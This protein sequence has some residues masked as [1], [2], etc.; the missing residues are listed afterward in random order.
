MRTD[1]LQK[2]LTK[3]CG[4]AFLGVF[5]R[6]HLPVPTARTCVFVANTDPCHLDGQH[7]ICIHVDDEKRGEYFDSFGRAPKEICC[8]TSTN[9][10]DFGHLI[11][12]NYKAP[13]VRFV[14]NI[15]RFTVSIAAKDST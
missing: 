13:S 4:D 7:W 8:S 14:V 15:V 10:A 9:I 1:Q 12:D 2:I 6:N 5:P 11:P 3:L